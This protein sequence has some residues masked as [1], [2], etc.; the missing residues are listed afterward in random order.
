MWLDTLQPRVIAAARER[1]S[2][3]LLSERS[4][5]RRAGISQP[6][7][8]N[9]LHGRKTL[10]PEVADRILLVLR[11]SALDLLGPEG[12][13]RCVPV[14]DGWIGPG[15][16]YPSGLTDEWYPV[17]AGRL[18]RLEDPAM[19]RL[20][21]D[22]AVGRVFRAGDLALL[23]RAPRV[24]LRPVTGN[25]FAVRLGSWGAVRQVVRCV[26]GFGLAGDDGVPGAPYLRD[27]E[28]NILDVLQAKL[29][30]IGRELE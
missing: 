4:L 14:L 28:R 2:S 29:V 20:A 3:G 25:W 1:V 15:E 19:A 13:F 7:I 6:H 26:E 10:T 5:A 16:L 23:E 21:G 9:V 24:R 8:H 11:L 27:G 18:G 12:G 17:A 30:W 22:D